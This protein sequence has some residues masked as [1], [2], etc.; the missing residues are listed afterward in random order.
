M[1]LRWTSEVPPPIVSAREYRNPSAHVASSAPNGPA[2]EPAC[3][4]SRP[5]RRPA[6]SRAGRA[7]RRAPCAP[8]SPGRAPGRAPSPTRSAAGSAAAPRTRCRARRASGATRGSASPPWA[9]TMSSSVS[10]VGPRPHSAPSPESDT[11]S[12]PSVTFA[13]RQP[14]FSSPTISSAGMRTPSRN[15]SL[16]I[17]GAV[18]LLDRPHGDAGCAHV[19]D[20][21]RDPAVLLG[22]RIGAGE[23]D[24]VLGDVGERR[25]DL[26]AVHDVLVAVALGAG[27]Q[28]RE[29]AAGARL[30]EQ[31]APELGAGEDPGEVAVLLLLGA[32]DEERRPGPADADRVERTRGLR[33]RGAPR[34]SRAA[35]PG[36]R[37][38]RRAWASAVRRIPPPPSRTFQSDGKRP[39]GACS[40]TNA[41]TSSR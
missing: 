12:L 16:N 34:R 38:V 22:R 28:R 15:T 40:R 32:G 9:R 18:H 14:S 2:V 27:R 31:L 39:P 29:V 26:L 24:P 23:Q 7:R 25:P 17:G 41:R 4:R 11:R 37:R 10:A 19:D 8:T 33:S 36:R 21:V 30:A 13:R 35:A 20:E 3:P 1:M 6:P 5:A